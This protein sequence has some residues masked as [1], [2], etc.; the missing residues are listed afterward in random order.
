MVVQRLILV[1]ILRL[2]KD[3]GHIVFADLQ[4]MVGIH[5]LTFLQIVIEDVIGHCEQPFEIVKGGFCIPSV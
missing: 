3:L 1:Y 5:W 4:R 2:I